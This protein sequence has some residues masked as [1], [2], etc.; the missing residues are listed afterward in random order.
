MSPNEKGKK[1]NWFCHV[2]SFSSTKKDQNRTQ[3]RRG[4]ERESVCE[5]KPDRPERSLILHLHHAHPTAT[6]MCSWSPICFLHGPDVTMSAL[7]TGGGWWST[8]SA[9]WMQWVA[10]CK[11]FKM[12]WKQKMLKQLESFRPFHAQLCKNRQTEN[13]EWFKPVFGTHHIHLLLRSEA[14]N[15]MT[16]M[17]R[18]RSSIA[19]MWHSSL[20]AHPLSEEV[21]IGK[22]MR[23]CLP[24]TFL[25]KQSHI[26]DFGMA[27]TQFLSS[28]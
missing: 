24:T 13:R 11:T 5:M 18:N 1:G 9:W 7:L 16:K 28:L 8:L 2:S 22:W 26:G 3:R 20:R 4:G 6:C 15:F 19:C 23:T 10:N 14:H 27:W 12:F 25:T 17:T 21:F